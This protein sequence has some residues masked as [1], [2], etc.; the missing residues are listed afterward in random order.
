[1][2]SRQRRCSQAAR[3]YREAGVNR[4]SLG[5][6]SFVPHVLEALNRTHNPANVERAI[7]WAR[8]AGFERLSV[9][10]IYGTPSES[11]EDWRRSLTRAIELGVDHVS[12]YA[13]TVETGTPLGARVAAGQ[14]PAPDDDVQADDYAIADELLGAA[15]LEW[16]EI[17]NWARAG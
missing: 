14:T 13:L 3:A 11:D 15:G 7:E 12:A 2:Q 5:V 9:D 8:G 6:Q 17:S 10:L 1:M 4:I 16:Y